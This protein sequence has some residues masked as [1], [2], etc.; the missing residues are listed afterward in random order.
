MIKSNKLIVFSAPSGAGKT[1]LVKYLLSMFN[2]IEFSISATSRKPR[3]KEKDGVDYYFLS[4]LEFKEKINKNEF[5]EYEEVYGGYYYGTLKSELKRI[6]GKNKIVIFDIDVV[7]GVNIKEMFFK[8]TLSVFVM[9]PSL[10]ILEKRLID[11]GDISNDEIKTR[12]E[13][14]EN[15]LDFASK[16]DNII[17]NSDLDESKKIA[18]SLI[19]EFIENE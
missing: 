18:F 11:R 19:K 17:I 9:P 6:W 3:G 16:F 10:R 14:A 8:E 15:E 5:V 13:K 1:T 2:E 4:D 12:T 7:G